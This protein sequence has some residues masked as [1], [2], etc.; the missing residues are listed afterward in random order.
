MSNSSGEWMAEAIYY[1]GFPDRDSFIFYFS[2][3]Y[4]T[5]VSTTEHSLN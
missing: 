5:T 4:D 1:N 2:H 3:D